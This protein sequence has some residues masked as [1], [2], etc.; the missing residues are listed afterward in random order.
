[1]LGCDPSAPPR[2]QSST[3]WDGGPF[4]GAEELNKIKNE[5]CRR[6]IES[7]PAAPALGPRG[8]MI[9]LMEEI[10]HQLIG[11]LSGPII[12]RVLYIPGGAGFLNHQQYHVEFWTCHCF[13]SYPTW[14]KWCVYN[15]SESGAG[16]PPVGHHV[17]K[18]GHPGLAFGRCLS[19]GV[20]SEGI[21]SVEGFCLG[22][23]DAPLL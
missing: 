8:T 6:F 11:S 22:A 1:M 14:S 20:F 10:L 13:L 2:S 7:L 18:H 23:K 4:S 15:S 21:F 12:Y 5:K 3:M 19:W 17:G 16:Y 9:L